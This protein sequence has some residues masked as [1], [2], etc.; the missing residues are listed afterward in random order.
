MIGSI[1]I[2]E[3][4]MISGVFGHWSVEITFLALNLRGKLILNTGR[5]YLVGLLA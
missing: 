5:F 4:P 3:Y 2:S 1:P